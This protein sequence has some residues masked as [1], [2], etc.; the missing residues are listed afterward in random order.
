M[1]RAR[2]QLEA[3]VIGTLAAHVAILLAL[4]IGGTWARHHPPAVV[5]EIELDDTP[6]PPPEVKP[7]PPPEIKP[8][9]A[10]PIPAP[11]T[12]VHHVART[13]SHAPP[14][15]EP[16]P[17]T[18]PSPTPEP[19]TPGGGDEPY[20]L[21]EGQAGSIAVPVAACGLSTTMPRATIR[22]AVTRKITSRTSATSTNGVTLMSVMPGESSSL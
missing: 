19:P 8:P 16:P 15:P 11:S 17:Q 7:P 4:D 9:P 12:V 13:E 6:P 2:G 22:R 1:R 21:P 10:P 3:I 20:K 5:E 18:P 14:S